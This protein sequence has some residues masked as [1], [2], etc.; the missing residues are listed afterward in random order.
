MKPSK[1]LLKYFLSTVILFS[2]M[3]C[4]PVHC[5]ENNKEDNCLRVLFVGNSLTYVNDLPNTFSAL[6]SSGGHQV[7]VAMIAEG[8]A[9]LY[10]HA[11]ATNFLT[12]LTSSQWDYVVLQEQSQLP[13]IEYSRI[14]DMYPAI[15]TLTKQAKD[16]NAQPI[17]FQTWARQGGSPENGMP[18]YESMQYEVDQGYLRIANELNIPTAYVGLAWFRALKEHP[19]LQLWQ[20]DGNHPTEQG[21]YLAACIFYVTLFHETPVGLKYHGNLAEDI[22]SQLQDTAN[23]LL[24]D[25]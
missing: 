10:D 8:G 19:Q 12:M 4:G 18:N 9:H 22:T 11:S 24:V 23:T 17:L 14:N 6:A 15:R 5:D 20:E 16:N 1:N 25:P 3:G 7:E 2:L 21:T 13:A